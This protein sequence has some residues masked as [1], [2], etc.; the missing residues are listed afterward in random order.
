MTLKP[1]S[2]GRP[3]GPEPVLVRRIAGVALLRED[4]SALM[5]LRDNKPGLN[6]AGL[7]VFPGGHCEPGESAGTAARREFFEETGYVCDQLWWVESFA[8]PSDDRRVIYELNIY[9]GH[10]DG[11]QGVHCYEGQRVA[12]IPRELASSYPMPAYVPRVWDLAMSVLQ[13][14]LVRR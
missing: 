6:A 4:D 11:I 7:W 8:Y 14:S 2:P 12:F 13:R 10:Y 3:V 9:A 1:A 5:Q